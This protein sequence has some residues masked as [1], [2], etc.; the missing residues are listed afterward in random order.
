[1]DSGLGVLESTR[2]V[3]EAARSVRIQSSAL[4]ALSERL[5]QR[6]FQRPAWR[7]EP[8]WWDDTE[9]TAQYVF[10]LDALNFCF[11]GDPKWHVAYNG[12][13][14]DGYW[15]LAACLRRALDEGVPIL[16]AQYLTEIDTA[17]A[18]HLL[19]GEG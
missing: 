11:W 10:V 19:R 2:L 5:A 4:S 1:M 8:H 17:T 15:A 16:D 18:R 13:T 3:L 14:W 9:R 12:Q 6:P 7:V